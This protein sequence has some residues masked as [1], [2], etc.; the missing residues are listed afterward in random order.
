MGN[1]KRSTVLSVVSVFLGLAGCSKSEKVGE[2]GTATL[3]T[4]AVVSEGKAADN[5]DAKKISCALA[6]AELVGS[7]L[8]LAGLTLRKAAD[9]SFPGFASCTYGDDN[10]GV[11][12]ALK[13]G[14]FGGARG[15]ASDRKLAVST[16]K[17]V[18][19]LE[20][21]GDEAYYHVLSAMKISST[22]VV[23]RKGELVVSVSTASSDLPKIKAL[24]AKLLAA[25]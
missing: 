3:G 1:L 12:L 25:H 8:G 4:T 20:G 7:M 24:V 15:Y 11:I 10:R 23:A 9:D 19:T 6:P 21:L 22:T 17:D 2:A 13:A 14:K 16:F 5:A 18:T